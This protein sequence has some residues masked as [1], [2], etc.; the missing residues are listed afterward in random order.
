MSEKTAEQRIEERER[1]DHKAWLRKMLAAQEEAGAIE[2]TGEGEGFKFAEAAR[3]LEEA[4]RILHG[5]GFVVIPANPAAATKLKGDGAL[6]K[7]GMQFEV[8]DSATGYT[9]V[10]DWTGHGYDERG[11]DKAGFMG[12]TG[13]GKY[14]YAFLLQMPFVDMDPEHVG[15]VPAGEPEPG[16]SPEAQKVAAEQDRAAEEP[17]LPPR[18]PPRDKAL[19]E[20]DLPAPDWDGLPKPEP[21]H[22]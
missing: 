13:A 14:F 21:A 8:S 5:H 1:K 9:K 20:S 19:P 2:R 22:A 3:V 18:V 12:M 10:I 16:K 15:E 7:V 17:D 11:G 4:K 6:T